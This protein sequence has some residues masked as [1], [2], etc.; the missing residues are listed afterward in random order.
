MTRRF[1]ACGILALFIVNCQHN[2]ITFNKEAKPGKTF[3]RSFDFYVAGLFPKRTIEYSE[4]CENEKIFQL[5]YYRTFSDGLFHL[6]TLSI[7]SPK[8]LEVVCEAALN[9]IH[10]EKGFSSNASSFAKIKNI[11]ETKDEVQ[12]INVSHSREFF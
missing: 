8:T 5:H 7:Y 9:H 3:E 2:R 10:S 4:L 11:E 12:Q 6:F 1:A